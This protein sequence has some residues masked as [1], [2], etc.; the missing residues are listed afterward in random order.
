V[1]WFILHGYINSQENRY[2]N[3]E[4]SQILHETPPHDLKLGL[5]V[6]LMRG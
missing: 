1:A 2:W 4:D 5:G 3:S 6:K